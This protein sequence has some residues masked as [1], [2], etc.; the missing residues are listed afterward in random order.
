MPGG[1]EQTS[2][3]NADSPWSKPLRSYRFA[4]CHNWAAAI[5]YSKVR[6]ERRAT[7]EP[8]ALLKTRRDAR[9]RTEQ[10]AGGRVPSRARAPEEFGR[11]PNNQSKCSAERSKC[12]R[13]ARTRRTLR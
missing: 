13:R 1:T 12:A 11:T 2:W 5:L 4:K 6:G 7:H 3:H 10:A 8:E 9:R